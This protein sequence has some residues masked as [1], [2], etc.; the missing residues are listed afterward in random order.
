[1]HAWYE[2]TEGGSVNCWGSWASWRTIQDLKVAID[3]YFVGSEN[4]EPN[5]G[6]LESWSTAIKLVLSQDD[7]GWDRKKIDEENYILGIVL[8]WPND[9][10]IASQLRWVRKEGKVYGENDEREM[11][12]VWLRSK[13]V[14]FCGINER[15]R[16]K[17]IEERKEKLKKEKRN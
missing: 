11:L 14:K 9:G 13:D 12:D 1:M 5:L 6:W 16:W 10:L 4:W 17:E 7:V 15:E 3:E 8:Q 2:W